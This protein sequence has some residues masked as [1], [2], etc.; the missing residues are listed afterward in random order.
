VRTIQGSDL[1]IPRRL[2]QMLTGKGL[3]VNI[4]ILRGLISGKGRQ[5]ECEILAWKGAP[6]SGQA[7]SQLRVVEAPNDLPDGDY[8]LQVDGV[9]AH[10]KKINGSWEMVRFS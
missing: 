9:S 7:Y 4:I 3:I 1:R 6:N 8:T 2:F 5:A 10:T